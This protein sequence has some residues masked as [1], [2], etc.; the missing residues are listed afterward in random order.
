MPYVAPATVVTGTTIASA[1]GNSVK[2]AT[3][4]LEN[5]P[6]C[7]CTQSGNISLP[8]AAATLITWDGETYD[9][10]TMHSTVSLTSRITVN[11]AGLYLVTFNYRTFGEA[12]LAWTEG[13][14]TVNGTR[15]AGGNADRNG[16]SFETNQNVTAHYKATVGQYFEAVVYQDNTNNVAINFLGN[17]GN[18]A[19]WLAAVRLGAG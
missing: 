4:F 9:T 6:A 3:D 13:I 1:W 2:A 17:S 12:T 16:A 15:I 10:D 14:I 19:A 11:T 5:P 8:D 7:R 18:G